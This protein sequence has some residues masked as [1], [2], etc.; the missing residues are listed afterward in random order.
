MTCPTPEKRSY[1]SR[2]AARFFAAADGLR[3]YRCACGR[4]HLSSDL[5]GY[6]PRGI[7]KQRPPRP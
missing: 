6:N 4:W 3:P 1:E 2:G 5:R 7:T